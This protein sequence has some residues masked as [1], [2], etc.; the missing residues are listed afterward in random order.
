VLLAELDPLPGILLH[1]GFVPGQ[2]QQAARV[3]KGA[4]VLQLLGEF[5]QVI[6][7]CVLSVENAPGLTDEG[8]SFCIH[9]LPLVTVFG[10]GPD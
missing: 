8:S 3:A 7:A 9:A 10:V 5:E 4:S 6:R 2:F 1:L